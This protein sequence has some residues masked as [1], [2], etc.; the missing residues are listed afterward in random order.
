MHF[1]TALV[2]AALFGL[3][4]AAPTIEKRY[5]SGQCGI[6]VTQF[7]KNEHNVG[8]KY[9]FNVLIKDANGYIIGGTSYQQVANGASIDITSQLPHPLVLTAGSTD[10]DPVRFG[11]NGQH[12]SS[13]HGCSLGKYDGGNRDMDCGFHCA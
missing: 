9:R 8:P 13:N 10:Q 4:S 12:W 5:A 3:S 1:S 7:Q 2:T 11:Y 6:H